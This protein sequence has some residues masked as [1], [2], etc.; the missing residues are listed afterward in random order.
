[1]C[2]PILSKEYPT[3]PA[4]LNINVGILNIFEFTFIL[5]AFIDSINLLNSIGPE[6]PIS[7]I[8][9]LIA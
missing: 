6:S 1:M 5:E 7:K 3:N 8:F 9:F 2:I 4:S